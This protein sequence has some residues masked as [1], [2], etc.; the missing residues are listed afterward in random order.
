MPVKI[1]SFEA[2]SEDEFN[3]LRQQKR[4]TANPAMVE[5]LNEVEAGRPIRVPLVEGQSARGLRVAISRAATSRGLDVETLEGD[6]FVAVRKVDQPR[7]RKATQAAPGQGKRRG[8]P[9]KRQEQD[10][11]EMIAFEDQ[12]TDLATGES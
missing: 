9:P 2:F 4:G 3:A 7:T 11:A 10:Q 1:G 12:A 8:R 5:L 6:G